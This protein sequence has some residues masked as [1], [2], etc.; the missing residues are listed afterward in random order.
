MPAIKTDHN[1]LLIQ[2]NLMELNNLADY[3]MPIEQCYYVFT[4]TSSYMQKQEI[5]LKFIKTKILVSKA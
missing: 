3:S 2:V 4:K 5:I 1:N